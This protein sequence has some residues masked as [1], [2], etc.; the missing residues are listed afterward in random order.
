MKISVRNFCAM[1][2]A[3]IALTAVAQASSLSG[4]WSGILKLS[5]QAQLKLVL[6]ISGDDASPV[7]TLDS[8][9]QGAFGLPC[10][11]N[12]LLPDSLN[13]S[14]SRLMVNYAA[15]LSESGDSLS[16][17]FTQGALSLPLSLSKTLEEVRRPQTPV[18]PFP[19]KEKDVKF[20]NAE[21]G[22]VLAATLTLPENFSARTPVVLMVSG[23]G[24]QNRDEEVFGHRPF[25]VVADR[26][27][28]AGIASLRYD[29][30]GCGASSG[31]PSAA[32]TRD[33]AADAAAGM[34]YLREV[35]KF[36]NVGIYGHS[37]GA[38][39]ACMLGASDGAATPDFI[40]AVGAPAVRG[41]SI[42]ADQSLR[43]MRKAGTPET[44]LQKYG[45]ALLALY[46]VVIRDGKKGAQ[47][48]IAEICA[49]LNDGPMETALA[50]ILRMIPD[51]LN[52]W[53][54]Y[55]I[56]YSPA[57]DIASVGVPM[58]VA[59]GEKDIQVSP[60]IN[61]PAMKK[62]APKAFVKEYAG[63]N[64][65]MQHAKTGEIKEYADIEE[66]ISEELLSDIISFILA[67]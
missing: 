30:R 7:V 38:M 33:F 40:V 16:G 13:I 51:A 19:Y 15:R 64:H 48:G 21:A 37:E 23:S 25:A 8:P 31:D 20:E 27:A 43:M 54:E 63:L 55:F 44:I 52:P 57:V 32:T 62:V 50:E 29:D 61:M 10:E 22:A 1:F 9:D 47:D 14:V 67:R 34:K 3:S 24:L 4:K 58:F 35:E 2:L 26:L 60:E 53:L 41:D 59:Y 18:A 56:G 36:N 11:V 45:E 42:L 5:P 6:N 49:P 28:R 66:T 46:D 17:I 65:M 12:C 39:V